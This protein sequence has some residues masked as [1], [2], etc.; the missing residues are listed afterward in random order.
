MG[1]LTGTQMESEIRNNLGG[2]TDLNSRLYIFLNWAQT[3]I[4]RQHVFRELEDIDT[5]QSTADGQDYIDHPTGIRDLYSIRVFDTTSSRKLI[6]VPERTFDGIVAKPDE[7]SEALPSH[8]HSWGTKFYLWRIPDAIYSV[9]IRY[10]KWPTDFTASSGSTSDLENLDE[11][12]CMLATAKALDSLGGSQ[13]EKTR[14]SVNAAR[15]INLAIARDKARFTDESVKGY[16]NLADSGPDY[17][18]DP[19]VRRQP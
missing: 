10:T 14:W 16:Y 4:S 18:L 19:F 17:W 9:R 7:Y 15:I 13:Q 3:E 1:T 8:Y 5:T 2:R 6:Y 11:A 12:I